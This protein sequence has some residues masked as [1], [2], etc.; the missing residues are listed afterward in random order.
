MS[1]K[2]YF[3]I[4]VFSIN[5]LNVNLAVADNKHSKHSIAFGPGSYSLSDTKQTQ[6]G[7]AITIEEDSFSV[8][9]IEYRYLMKKYFSIGSE[10]IGFENTYS[11]DSNGNTG[12]ITSGML[13]FNAKFHLNTSHWFKPYLGAQVGIAVLEF[14]GPIVGNSAGV[15]I[16]IVAGMEFPVS[17]HIGFHLEY[18]DI[19]TKPED[20][21]GE[22]TDISGNGIFG[23]LNIYF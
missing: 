17:R 9:Q 12:T 8:Y 15:V 22:L 10:F 1:P 11:R 4:I 14:D 16:S 23:G 21:S 2:H 18:K 13:L 19:A 20:S 5:L 6:L 7:L 3:V